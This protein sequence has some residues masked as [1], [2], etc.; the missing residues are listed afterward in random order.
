MFRDRGHCF[1]DNVLNSGQGEGQDGDSGSFERF[2]GGRG[3]RNGYMLLIL[4]SQII[5]IMSNT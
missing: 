5:I 3:R 4:Q 1:R 2:G